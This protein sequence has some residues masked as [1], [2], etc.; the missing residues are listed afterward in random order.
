MF[1]YESE[2]FRVCR[3]DI[4]RE[5]EIRNITTI[6]N[7][8]YFL[9]GSSKVKDGEGW[10]VGVALKG[11]GSFFSSREISGW[12]HEIGRERGGERKR[13]GTQRGLVRD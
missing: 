12:N 3:R 5:Y 8:I 6:N 13:F 1:V 9:S 2:L 10:I 7:L 4:C 11:A